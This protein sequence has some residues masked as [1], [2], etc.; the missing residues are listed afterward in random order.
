MSTPVRIAVLLAAGQGTR[1]KSRLP[2]VL[3]HVGGR[4]MAA[5]VLDIARAAGCD[6]LVV[7][8]GHGAERVREELAAP[9]VAFVEQT[10]RLGT[11]HALACAE[12]AVPGDATMIVLSGDVPLIRPETLDRLAVAAESAWGA[13][14][15]AEVER[16]GSLGRI[17][18]DPSGESLERIVEA[19]DADPETLRIR[20]INAGLYALPAPEIFRTIEATGND[21]AKGE[22]Y[23]TDALGLAV[24][25]GHRLAL[26][27]L[28]DPGESFG[29][30]DRVDLAHAELRL[31]SR[32][33]EAHQRA[34]VTVLD[35]AR[36]IIESGVEIGPDTVLHPG[37]SLLG[38][39]VVGAGCELHQGCWIRDSR[40]ADDVVVE[41]Y[42]VFD[43]AVVA[44]GCRIG[45]YARLRP[46]AELLEGARVGNFVEIKKSRLGPGAK[47]NHLTYIGDAEI[48]RGTNV[49]AGTVT[50]N[51]D[52]TRKHRTEIGEDAFIGSDTMLVAPVRV[53]DRATTGSGSV[54]T[55]NVPADALAVGRARQRNIEDWSRRRR[56]RD[57]EGDR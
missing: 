44:S 31:R 30:N 36:T 1:M 11:G 17:V 54:I 6:R 12:S 22:Y 24:A 8:V 48:G 21:N 9:D 5:R 53:G 10:E 34:G 55:Q 57:G 28:P 45:P 27:D 13:L 51:Y 42:S 29:V 3:H 16:P 26:V 19:A 43:R 47:V 4:P 35:P 25:R 50:C 14:A 2:K 37:V 33:I 15:V 18:A 7:V 20:R 52:G 39:T 40:L 49:G 41:P 23:L 32:T 38:E 56:G 46:D